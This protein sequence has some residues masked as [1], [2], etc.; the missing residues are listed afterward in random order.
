MAERWMAR[1]AATAAQ[2]GP[3]SRVL[4]SATAHDPVSRLAA[5]P[6]LD[7]DAFARRRAEAPAAGIGRRTGTAGGTNR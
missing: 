7:P 6:F 2:G 3:R 5:R 1:I 4:E